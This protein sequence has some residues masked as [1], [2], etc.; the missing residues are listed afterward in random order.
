LKGSPAVPG[1][2]LTSKPAWRDNPKV[3]GRV[4]LFYGR[5][6]RGKVAGSIR[7]RI[8]GHGSTGIVPA[9]TYGK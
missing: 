8:T 9:G 5:R 2:P 6:W 4:G 1:G 7:D 3:S